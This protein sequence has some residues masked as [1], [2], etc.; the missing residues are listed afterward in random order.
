MFSLNE[1]IHAYITY[2]HK[3]CIHGYNAYIHK[4]AYTY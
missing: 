3:T 4:H 2:M 1:H